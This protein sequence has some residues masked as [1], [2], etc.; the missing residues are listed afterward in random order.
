MSVTESAPLR[1]GFSFSIEASVIEF[2]ELSSGCQSEV[3]TTGENQMI[4]APVA[5]AVVILSP[6]FAMV[7]IAQTASFDFDGLNFV[8]EI[9]TETIG[10]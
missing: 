1:R 5:A 2:R 6:L 9:E 3:C 4:R 8:L 10:G 7:A